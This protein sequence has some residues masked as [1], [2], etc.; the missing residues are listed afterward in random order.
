M[1]VTAAI[2]AWRREQEAAGLAA[3]SGQQSRCRCSRETWFGSSK[4][5][6]CRQGGEGGG[7]ALLNCSPAGISYCDC[8]HVQLGAEPTPALPPVPPP[9]HPLPCLLR[10]VQGKSLDQTLKD[11][12]LPVPNPHNDDG[13]RQLNHIRCGVARAGR[14]LGRQSGCWAGRQGAG[15]AGV[16]LANGVRADRQRV[17]AGRNRARGNRTEA[18]AEGAEVAVTLECAKDRPMCLARC[19]GSRCT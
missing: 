16:V 6:S 17:L 2:P 5:T 1:A 14:V 19:A 3:A 9:A 7:G 11:A 4:E 13:I 18:E 15:Q 12:L 8:L 10:W